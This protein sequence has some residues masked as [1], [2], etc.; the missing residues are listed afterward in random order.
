[1][2]K[3]AQ[4]GRPFVLRKGS[5]SCCSTALRVS[6]RRVR[7]QIGVIRAGIALITHQQLC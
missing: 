4:T 2:T 6:I 3:G 5:G 1:M 7:D